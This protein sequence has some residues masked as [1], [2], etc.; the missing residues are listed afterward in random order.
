MES[1]LFFHPIK[2]RY[3]P[4]FKQLLFLLFIRNVFQSMDFL[5]VVALFPFFNVLSI[6]GVEMSAL[7]S[8]TL[9]HFSFRFSVVVFTA[10]FEL[11]TLNGL[12]SG[13]TLLF[14]RESNR[15]KPI[16]RHFS[17]TTDKPLH[18]HSTSFDQLIGFARSE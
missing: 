4:F 3:L 7:I 14:D 5:V 2:L 17:R 1:I 10:I 12:I 13:W 18:S 8:F 15:F 11:F 6:F 16:F 9:R